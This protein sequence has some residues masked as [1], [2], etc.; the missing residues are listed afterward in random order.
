MTR[1]R[2]L[3]LGAGGHGKVMADLLLSNGGY[4]VAGFVDAAPR[5]GQVL[6]L[7][8]LG[9]ESLLGALFDQGA[10]LA[11][12]AIGHNEQR[13]AAAERLKA[14]GFGLPS[15]IHPSAL[16]GRAVRLGDG[17]AIL[18]RAV[19][20]PEAA[21]GALALINT[22]AIVEHDCVVAEAAHIGPGAVLTGGV[23]VGAGALIGAG[24]VVRPGIKIG[25]GAVIGAG[26]AVVE[27]IAPG[28]RV[29]G[30][31]AQEW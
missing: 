11:H 31:P 4:E 17:A 23:R 2:I 6:G 24:A 12:P 5:A 8:V 7:P 27:D 28:A 10:A 21:I 15:L 13:Q 20:G 30:V 22:G 9:D 25:A 29:T 19:I 16:I 18:A 3:L 14:A 1:P 26:A